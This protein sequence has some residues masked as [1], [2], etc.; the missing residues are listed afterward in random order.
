MT[1]NEACDQAKTV[2]ALAD[3]GIDPQEGLHERLIKE[4]RE[5]GTAWRP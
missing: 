2:C 3:M 1:V 4:L 5:K